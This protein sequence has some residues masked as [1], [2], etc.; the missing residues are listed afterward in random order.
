MVNMQNRFEMTRSEDARGF[1]I[2]QDV[3][4]RMGKIPLELD[5]RIA[6]FNTDNY[7]AR[8]YAYEQDIISGFSFSPLYDSG[9]RGYLMA[10]FRI[11][12]GMRTS[13][14]YASSYFFDKSTIGS[15]YDEIAGH[16]RNEIKIS[17]AMIF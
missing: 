2:Y 17:L 9:L 8:I 7:N 6:W 4:Y 14:R 10:T 12:P 15:G 3:T 16:S 1:L 5:F 13:L 11:T